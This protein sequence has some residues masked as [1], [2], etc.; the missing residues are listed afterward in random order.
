MSEPTGILAAMA[1]RIADTAA[2]QQGP[3]ADL[4]PGTGDRALT[5]QQ[6]TGPYTIRLT[7]VIST[8]PE[9]VDQ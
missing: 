7:A 6:T 1:R 2:R 5:T 9:A 4:T 8:G 3:W